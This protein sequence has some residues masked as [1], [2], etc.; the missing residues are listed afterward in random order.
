MFME[1]TLV[2]EYTVLYCCGKV[3]KISTY[4]N[5]N[6]KWW[7]GLQ[8]QTPGKKKHNI[9]IQ[10][11]SESSRNVMSKIKFHKETIIEGRE[12]LDQFI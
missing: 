1:A 11:Q 9:I 10:L 6:T 12:D 7:R 2:C 4:P 8:D 3:G 5:F